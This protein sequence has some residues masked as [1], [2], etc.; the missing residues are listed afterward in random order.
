MMWCE[1]QDSLVVAASVPLTAFPAV[2][3]QELL[4]C[5]VAELSTRCRS[6]AS[7]IAC[8]YEL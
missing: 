6:I 5:L 8:D 4:C 2:R 3:G 1:L 7:M